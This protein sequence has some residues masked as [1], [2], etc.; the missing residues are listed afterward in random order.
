M[1]GKVYNTWDYIKNLVAIGYIILFIVLKII[2]E[3]SYTSGV[4]KKQT[5]SMRH[6][7]KKYFN[8]VQEYECDINQ[9]HAPVFKTCLSASEYI[10]QYI[11]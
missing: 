5:Y 6:F 7:V 2:M 8:V 9:P 11:F 4:P 1:K 3:I 10:L